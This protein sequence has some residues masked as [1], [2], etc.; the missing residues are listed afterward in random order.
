M[1]STERQRRFRDKRLAELEARRARVAEME[2]LW[3]AGP[4]TIAAA[5]VETL[6]RRKAAAVARRVL[7]IT[8]IS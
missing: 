2:A 7:T 1:T 3:S 6:G 4:V 8:A 5:L